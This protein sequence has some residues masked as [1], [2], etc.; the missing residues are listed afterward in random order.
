MLEVLKRQSW[1][2]FHNSLLQHLGK[3]IPVVR[4]GQKNLLSSGSASYMYAW[5]TRPFMLILFSGG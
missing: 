4:A 3:Q 5:S 1:E 2:K